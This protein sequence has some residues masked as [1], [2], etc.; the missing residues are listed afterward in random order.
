MDP[1]IQIR[2]QP[3]MSWIRNTG[4]KLPE[5]QR[6]LDTINLYFSFVGDDF[7]LPGTQSGSIDL[8]ESGSETLIFGFF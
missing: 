2:I 4:D 3:K 5:L 6:N 8:T 1:R 7:G